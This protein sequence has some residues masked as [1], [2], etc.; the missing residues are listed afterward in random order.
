[1]QNLLDK[2]KHD[3]LRHH[4]NHSPLDDVVV[5]VDEEFYGC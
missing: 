3:C 2:I 5:R 1:M 4:V